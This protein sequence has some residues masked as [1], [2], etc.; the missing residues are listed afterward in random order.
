MSGSLKLVTWNVQGIGHVIKRKKILTHLKKQKSDIVLLQETKL[1]D[2][3]HLKLRRDW[4]GRVYFSSHSQNKRGTAILIHKNIPFILEH[5]EKDPEGRF[6]LITGSILKKHITILNVYAPNSDSPHFISEIVL[7][8]NHYCKGLGFLAGDF[9]CIMN[10]SLDKSSSANV[11]NPRS[12]AALND[13]C[14]DTGLIDIWRQINPKL[15]DYTFYSHPHKSYSRLDYF[16]I[17]KQFL[18]AVQA[19]R[20]DS[21]VLSDHAPVLLHI[22]P[23]L[24]IP[25]TPIWRFNTSLLNSDPFCTFVR[26][27]LSQFWIDNKN[28][29]VSPAMIWDAAKATLRGHLIS[30]TSHQKKVL[31]SNRKNLVKE[32]TRLE[33]IH[34]RSPTVVNLKALVSAKTT[35]NIDHTRHVQ[36]LLLF[37]K[38]KYYEF[39]NKCS[40]LLAHQLKNQ[41]NDRSIH[42]IRTPC[43]DDSCDPFT[44]NSTFRDFYKSLYSSETTNSDITSYL[45]NISLPTVAEEERSTLN[46]AFTPEEVWSAIQAMPNGKCPGPDGFPLECYKKF[47][48][49]IHPILMPAINNILKGDIPPSWRYASVSLL[50]KKDKN[51]LDCSSYRPISLLNV[52]YKIVAKVLARRLEKVLPNIINSDQA[53]FVK[54]RHGT[55]NVRRALNVIHYLNTHKNPGFIISLDAEKAFD[56]VEWPFLFSVLEKFDLGSSFINVI[57]TLYSDPIASVN[58]N[59]LM[60]EGFAVRRGCRQGCPLSPLLFTLFIEPLAEVIRTNL[61]ITGITAGEKNHVISLFAD[62]VL[63]YLSDPE[64]SVPAVLDSITLFSALSGYKIN[65]GKSVALAFN[66]PQNTTI[67]SPFRVSKNG[68]KYLGIFLTPDLN[69]LFETNY[70]PLIQKLRND[71]KKWTS[72][73]T[74]FFGRINT[75]KMNILPRLNYLFQ[76]LPCYL[77]PALFNSLNSYISQYIWN[78]KHQ[79]VRFSKLTKPKELGGLSLPN[80]Q[81]YYW[82]AQL[83]MMTNWFIKKR[84]SL[85]ISLESLA[86]HPRRLESL[87]FINDIDQ[88]N[89]LKKNIIIYNTLQVWRDVRK[90]LNIPSAISARSPLALNP[91]LPVQIRSIGL[92]EWASKG[93]P[94]VSGLLTSNSVKPFEQIRK[95]FDI[96]CKDFFKYLQIRHFVESLVRKNEIRLELSELESAMLSA[97][98]FKGLISKIHSLL[99]YSV[100]S[101]Y[102]SLKP[103][104]ERDLEVTFSSA[105]WTKICNGIFP[106]CISTSIHEQNFK[107]FHRTYF[108]PVRLQKMFPHSSD[109]CYKCRTHKGTFIHLFWACD[110]IQTFWKEVHS[111]VQEVIGKQF[112]L[113]PSFYLLNHTL[114]KNLDTDTKYLLIILSFLAK[115]CILLRWSAPQVPTVGMWLSQISSL[116]PLEKLTYDLNHNPDR[117]WRLWRPLHSFLERL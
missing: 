96:P 70:S 20:I 53:G 44:I 106:K 102:D 109:L 78:N 38:Q 52:D 14:K 48:P 54:S 3:E 1:S 4:V 76:N 88:L 51:P 107:F 18:H 45:N 67:Q 75:I 87:P 33:Q 21:I 92:L 86:C 30:Y 100:S 73:P 114:D 10:A 49:E 56:R 101:A 58:T 2:T 113:S 97:K 66:I 72:L 57:K 31:E 89:S 108:T 27:S 13:L 8:F 61:D 95:D 98:S 81:L 42:V 112:T 64:K 5:E 80:L 94:E 40:R 83:K 34:K 35:L 28:P 25:R 60:S 19:C 39:G 46:A 11:S 77:T 16:F 22:D 41:N 74:S 82:S 79:R 29:Q 26:N 115:K 50:L 111:V 105:D 62:D 17:P 116:L 24:T 104:W 69:N 93:L 110:R 91:D 71:L 59:G 12:S 43:G 15:R 47:W 63:L 103:L 117:F 9:N 65:L 7:L 85:W 6:I 68:L 23:A 32:V 36:K 84:D 99:L 37:T 55:D 90:Y